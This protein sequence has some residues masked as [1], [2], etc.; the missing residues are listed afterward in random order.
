MISALIIAKD[1]ERNI[2]PCIDSL[3]SLADE[4]VVI[5]DS[6]STDRSREI[7]LEKGAKV[8]VKEWLGYGATKNWGL[9]HTSGDCILWID[10][11]ERM[12]PELASEIKNT[13]SSGIQFAALAFPRKAFFL[14][15]WIKH[16]GWYPGYVRR[17]FKRGEARF[18]DKLVH[19]KLI[20]SGRTIR[21]KNALI[22]FTDPDINRYFTK[23]NEYTRLAAEQMH[24]NG[25]RFKVAEAI[26]KPIFLF[27]KMYILKLGFLDGIEGFILCVFSSHYV[28]VKNVK[29]WEMQRHSEKQV[30]G[31]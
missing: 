24:L 25:R 21:L 15:K 12:T 30:N 8:F 2:G 23:F 17:L 29:L 7:A 11:D 18:D 31:Q 9:Q 16:C 13:M 1:E 27:V 20:V 28:F 14:G 5:M 22:H 19:E 6:T 26:L 3:K 4:T 10:A